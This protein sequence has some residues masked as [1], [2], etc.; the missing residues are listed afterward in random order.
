MNA[1][2]VLYHMVRADFLERVRRY[3]FLLT[4]GLAVYLGYA[5]YAGQ[6]SLRLDIYRGIDN[7]AWVGSVVGLVTTVWLSLI[8][9]YIVKNA[10]QRDRQTRVGQILAST[11]MSKSFYTLGKTLSNF[12]VL[13]SMVLILAVGAVAIQLLH[14][15]A[16]QID[17]VALLSPIL[18]LGLSAVAVTSALA[19]L[20]ESLPVLRGGVGNFV[21]FF[22][23]I[24]LVTAGVAVSLNGGHASYLQ[25]LRDFAGIG[26]MMGQMRTRLQHIDP[27]YGGQ[28]TFGIGPV[29]SSSKTFLWTGIDWTTGLIVGRLLWV[30]VAVGLALLAAVF[31]DRFDSA[32]DGIW[33]A[34]S[35]AAKKKRAKS[36]EA[37]ELSES[38]AG[39][40]VVTEQLS[41]VAFLT[42][43]ER[44]KT[45][46][47]RLF[48]L[49]AAEFRLLLRGHRWWWYV[50]AAGW[51]V[52]CLF[53]P[54]ATARS[55]LIAGAWIWPLL[56]WSQMGTREAQFSTGALIFSAPHAAPRQLLATYLAGVALAVVS[57]GGLG[58]HLLLGSDFAGLGAWAAGAAFIPA[59][60]LVLGVATGSRKAFEALYTAWWY[61]AVLHHIPG[62]D[63]MGTTAQSSTPMR[64]L[65]AALVLLL[66]AYSWRKV[67]LAYA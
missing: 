41:S 19:V 44:G 26:T 65:W 64:F 34:K 53:S 28:S 38:A 3:S 4:L 55:V 59:L 13:A 16:G 29:D 60:A 37:D 11:P 48:A 35:G 67:R 32:R 42:P 1:Q 14:G 47:M 25:G 63:F 40:A 43:L 5:V 66:I 61:T 9:F 27:H 57:G 31:F 18:L 24:A 21:Y 17:F 56:A 2:R 23:W 15:E 46:H 8:G 12:A 58:L 62:A 49:V 33:T 10:I 52:A 50:G 54:L 6:V 20:F 45:S 36:F 7:S 30:A 39:T 22:V 51:I